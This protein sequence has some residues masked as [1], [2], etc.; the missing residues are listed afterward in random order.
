MA[1]GSQLPVPLLPAHP[2]WIDLYWRAWDTAQQ[3]SSQIAKAYSQVRALLRAGDQ[4]AARAQATSY[5]EALATAGSRAAPFAL[6]PQAQLPWQ[7]GRPWPEPAAMLLE[8][9]LGFE[10]CGAEQRITWRLH[11]PP[12]AGVS[13]LSLGDNVV[14]LIAEGEVGGGIAVVVEAKRT[15]DL[16]IITE[17]TTFSEQ[18]PPGRTR[19]LLTY[20]DRTDI[21]QE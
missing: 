8:A 4:A 21:R 18:I 20:L 7:A 6:A 11:M 2:H 14:S 1:E 17:F 3:D 10:A 12:P 13:N 16:Q 15:L 9:I 19:Y 5:L